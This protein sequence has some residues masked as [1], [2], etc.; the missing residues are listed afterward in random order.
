MQQGAAICF[1]SSPTVV[2]PSPFLL[3]YLLTL[4]NQNASSHQIQISLEQFHK[5]ASMNVIPVFLLPCI[6]LPSCALLGQVLSASVT[7]TSFTF[8]HCSASPIPPSSDKTGIDYLLLYYFYLLFITYFIICYYLQL[9]EATSRIR[10][11]PFFCF[12]L[13]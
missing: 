12:T 1:S 4:E 10:P 9:L 13:R 8:Y 7:S 2:C 6:I 3:S 5:L 11:Y